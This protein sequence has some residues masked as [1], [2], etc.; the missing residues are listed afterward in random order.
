MA[1]NDESR[2]ARHSQDLSGGAENIMLP[3]GYEN[4]VP[5]VST[6]DFHITMHVPYGAF[7]PTLLS[8]NYG[9]DRF[10]GGMSLAGGGEIGPGQSCRL[11]ITAASRQKK[12]H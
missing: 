10:V 3:M 9:K 5:D 8:R 1:T 7:P 12:G 2:H 11:P 6:D 4:Y